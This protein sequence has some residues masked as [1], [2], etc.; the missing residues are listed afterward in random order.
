MVEPA[1]EPIYTYQTTR[2]AANG[3]QATVRLVALLFS[4]AVSSVVLLSLRDYVHWLQVR[5]LSH[6]ISTP[7]AT[8]KALNMSTYP[9]LDDFLVQAKQNAIT[10]LKAGSSSQG[11]VTLIMGNEAGDLDSASCA[12]ALSYLLTRFGSPP[13]YQLS[14]SNYVPL[15]QSMH[16][17]KVLRAENTVAYH[18]SGVNPN[19]VLFL[20][21]LQQY[22]GLQLDSESFSPS[23][24]VA[25]GLVDH[26][27]LTGPWGG[28]KAQNRQVEIILDHHQ[29]T[30][31]HPNA[32]LRIVKSPNKEAV[33][34]CSS[35]VAQLF[36][37]SF[38]KA[39]SND[40]AL[41]QV[42]DL[43]LSAIVIDTDNL[44]GAPRGKATKTD[45]EAVKILLPT[46]SFG[47]PSTS[48]EIKETAFSFSPLKA[49]Q[50]QDAAVEAIEAI[51]PSGSEETDSARESAKTILAPY[52]TILMRSKLA[53]SHLSGRDLLRRDYKQV[54]L[55]A[56]DS[57]NRDIS[58]K[59]GFASVPISLVEW[60]HK[61]RRY[62]RIS[63]APHAKQEV[64]EAWSAW[65]KT[66]DL[67]MTERK[68][69]IAVMTG[70]FRVP[71]GQV[72]AGKHK[73]ELVLA[74]APREMGQSQAE[75]LWQELTRGLENDAHVE[76]DD[77]DSRLMLQE[78]W[79]G[80][81]MPEMEGGKRERVK[82]VRVDGRREEDEW[83]WGKV[84][85]QANARAN[86]KI[87]LPAVTTILKA[88]VR[89]L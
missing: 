1:Y 36:A 12:I 71:E 56:H 4:V 16:A 45:F 15:I 27:S 8:Q 68:L 81:R 39:P 47:K 66:L 13:G 10:H 50:R 52:W 41:R 28:A 29:D 11:K 79:K 7:S 33:G 60:L 69:N 21:D 84:Y 38:A 14:P 32:A 58:L 9:T 49:S 75:K 59:L 6:A 3:N 46:S 31:A 62:A 42:S 82:G 20:V 57:S 19:K 61:D 34:S 26:A 89:K 67:F 48:E 40:V 18:A 17:D 87:V 2:A 55:S 64:Q 72:D 22:L 65:W 54:D 43:L 37:E 63:D 74:F 70:S 88:A 77:V 30:G 73:R 25:L 76:K 5:P 85:K 86:R 24:N 78:P 53:V 51:N 23:S 35:I 44:K 83:K 80:Q